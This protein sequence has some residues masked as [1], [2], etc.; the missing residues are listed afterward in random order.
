MQIN[1]TEIPGGATAAEGFSAAA[2]A[3]GI[4]YEGRDDMGLLFADKVCAAAATYTSNR[5]KAAP[6]LYDAGIV[7]STSGGSA[8]AIIVNA[9]IANACTGEEGM[10]L[11][12]ATAEAAARELSIKAEEVLVASTGVIGM[13]LPQEK[14]EAGAAALAKR[15][16]P[17]IEAGNRLV[18]AMMTT[19]T[20]P[21]EAAVS[22][23]VNG[24]KAT[25]GGCSKGSGMINP[26]MC[27]MLSFITG[28]PCLPPLLLQKGLHA[29][30]S[31]SFNRV[32]VDGDTSTN[33]TCIFL[34]NA[35][36]EIYEQMPAD[37]QQQEYQAYVEALTI[38][39]QKLAKMMARDGE[40]ATKFFGCRVLHAKDRET[41]ERLSDSVIA[42]PLCKT[43][44]YGSDANWGRFLCAMGYAGAAFDP[45]KT[46]VVIESSK[47]S[48][49]LV[50]GGQAADYS[51]EEATAILSE[52]SIWVICDLHQAEGE[53]GC[54][55][56]SYGCDLTYDYVKINGD[57]RS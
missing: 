18:R 35:D 30:V 57:Y 24:R 51:E 27:T 20:F 56:E 6:V 10:R 14:L 45:E 55:G 9:G 41:A 52:E 47:G 23:E 54:S 13:Q 15:L 7:G 34:S 4:K 50:K 22:Y 3:A 21:K 48:L 44:V 8:R 38:V 5:V 11:C 31:R 32:C 28:N 49:Q 33:D 19:D 37:Q 25:I 29:A 2:F 46:D 53:D 39:C 36:P 16:E 26:N 40:G 42:S 12:R 17:G 43:A 1:L